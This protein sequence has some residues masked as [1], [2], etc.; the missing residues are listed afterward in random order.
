MPEVMEPEV[1]DP[2]LFDRLSE[3]VMNY[4]KRAMLAKEDAI[5]VQTPDPREVG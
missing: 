2:C 1:L 4:P 3:G 5:R